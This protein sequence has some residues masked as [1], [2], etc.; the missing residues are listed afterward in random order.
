MDAVVLTSREAAEFLKVSERTLWKLTKEGKVPHFRV[1]RVVR[2][3]R[4][5]LLES[6][7]HGKRGV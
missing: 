2:Y 4:G 6:L 5:R 1:G 7:E 3:V